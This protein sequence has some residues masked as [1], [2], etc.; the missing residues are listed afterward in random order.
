MGVSKQLSELILL[1]KT[2]FWAEGI[3]D[4]EMDFGSTNS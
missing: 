1:K 3:Y 2:Y 4:K